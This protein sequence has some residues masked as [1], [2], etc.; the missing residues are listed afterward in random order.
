MIGLY[1]MADI[2]ITPDINIMSNPDNIRVVNKLLNGEYHVQ[3]ISTATLLDVELIVS[4]EAKLLLESYDAN[5]TTLKIIS[6]NETWIGKIISLEAWS[7][8]GAYYK[9]SLKFGTVPVG[10]S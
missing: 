3:T 7:R 6:G 9:T 1:T 5:N 2:L 4:K 10:G 8:I